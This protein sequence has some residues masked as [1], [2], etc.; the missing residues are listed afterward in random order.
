MLGVL[1]KTKKLEALVAFSSFLHQLLACLVNRRT[2]NEQLGT[3]KEQAGL[4]TSSVEIY[5]PG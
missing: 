4:Q 2:H 1:C 3:I 5:F